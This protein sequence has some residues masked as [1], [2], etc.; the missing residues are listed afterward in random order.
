MTIYKANQIATYDVYESPDGGRTIYKR[1]AG[2]SERVLH[3]IDPDLE[4]EI[5][6]ERDRN[7]W[8]DIFNTAERTPALQEA[9]D[10]VIVIYELAKDDKTLPPD[11]HPV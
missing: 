1:K 8:M 3:K 7:L 6:R 10:R 5:L 9:I 11:W 4:A 2:T